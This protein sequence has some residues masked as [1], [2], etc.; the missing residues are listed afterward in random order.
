MAQ[1]KLFQN[2][3]PEAMDQLQMLMAA[4]QAGALKNNDF[5]DMAMNLLMSNPKKAAADEEQ[6]RADI[7]MER[8][9]TSYQRAVDMGDTELAK[10]YA[11][12][13][14][15]ANRKKIVDNIKTRTPTGQERFASQLKATTKDPFGFLNP[16]NFVKTQVAAGNDPFSNGVQFGDTGEASIGNIFQSLFGTP[17]PR[18]AEANNLVSKY[19]QINMD[20]RPIPGSGDSY[21]GNVNVNTGY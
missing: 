8:D 13:M 14:L 7:Q 12:A 20:Q 15:P 9:Q 1:N 5:N 6:Q 18:I 4:N 17:D 19:K 3:T 10:Q 2:M 11:Y 21:P 16:L